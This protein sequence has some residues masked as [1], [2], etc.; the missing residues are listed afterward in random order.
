MFVWITWTESRPSSGNDMLFFFQVTER[1]IHRGGH[2]MHAKKMS[3]LFGIDPKLWFIVRSTDEF[4]IISSF[5]PSKLAI[6][7]GIF[8]TISEYKVSMCIFIYVSYYSLIQTL[9]IKS[10]AVGIFTLLYAQ[11]HILC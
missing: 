3:K 4:Q 10:N 6:R 11:T 5:I 2:K 9:L 1:Y 7:F 8:V